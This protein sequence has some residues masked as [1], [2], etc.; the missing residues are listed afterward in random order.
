M[1]AVLGLGRAT[2]ATPDDMSLE[3]LVFAACSAALADAGLSR[4]D[5][6]G[7][8]IAASDQLDGRSISSMHLAGPAGGHLRDEIKVS[9]DGSLAVATAAMRIAC[10]ATRRAL[11]VS[12]TKSSDSAPDP[13]QRVNGD[14][15]YE[16]PLGISTLEAEALLTGAFLERTGL[17]MADVDALS[18][19]LGGGA[20]DDPDTPLAE[21][22][23]RR[24]VPPPTDAAI[25]LV[26]GDDG[27]DAGVELAGLHWGAETSDIGGRQRTPEASLAAVA[28]RALGEA[29]LT[30]SD[31]VPLE[32][33][34]RTTFR[35]CMSVAGLGLADARASAR[36]L[37]AGELPRVN[38][39]GGLWERNPIFAA[40]LDCVARAV[41]HV[42]GG[43]PAAVA[44]SSYGFAGQGQMVAVLRRG[45]R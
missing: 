9:D 1:T 40:G 16:K 43:V 31:E 35:L 26:L 12:W 39:G 25:A 14:P 7:V 23:R 13:A 24:H 27:G 32:T 2:P 41:E 6:D 22:L 37:A 15:V 28:E 10:G 30:L 8:S 20:L 11:V 18:E 17:T 21:P 33:T 42:R 29:E 5:V 44:H 4:E 45:A 38:P 19:R 34:D 3:E 36:R